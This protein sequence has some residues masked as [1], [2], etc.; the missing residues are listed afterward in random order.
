MQIDLVDA[1][2]RVQARVPLPWIQADPEWLWAQQAAGRPAVRFGDMFL[3]SPEV[4]E[5]E[6]NPVIVRK[7]GEG[8]AAVDA[9]VTAAPV[10]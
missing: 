3:A 9:L 5:F 1:Q 7:K 8:L 2:R 10:R 6:I 4:Q